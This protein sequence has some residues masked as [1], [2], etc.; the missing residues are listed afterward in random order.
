VH[1][2]GYLDFVWHQNLA[3]GST[4]RVDVGLKPNPVAGGSRG[5]PKWLFFSVAAVSVVALGVGAYF[6][7]D[8]TSRASTE[9]EKDALQ[10]D[11]LEQEKIKSESTTANVLFIG[12]AAIAAG[13]GVLAF[14]TD[15]KGG[16]AAPRTGTR[17]AP[18]IGA[19]SAGVV[20]TG[21]F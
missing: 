9:K 4:T 3:D 13:A 17:V 1:A 19:S 6:G 16:G 10:R 8:A 2:P 11:P 5:T 7:F 20:V 12:G 15:W 18:L 21:G 14:T